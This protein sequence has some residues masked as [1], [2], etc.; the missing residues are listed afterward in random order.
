MRSTQNYRTR[1]AQISRLWAEQDYD[2]ALSNVEDLSSQWPGN[3]HLRVLWSNLIQLQHKPQ[4]DLSEARQALRQAIDLDETSPEAA[5]E[6]GHYL[7]NVEDNARGAAK[8]FSAAA[9]NA[10]SLLVEALVGEA[11]AL[12]ELGKKEDARHRLLEVLHVTGA[13]GASQSSDVR[14]QVTAEIDELVGT[15]YSNGAA[16]CPQTTARAVRGA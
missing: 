9:A 14:S 4:H 15:L 8:A 10:R 2:A 5:I 13:S 7:H 3:A 16:K 6:L 1:L 12:I 11:R